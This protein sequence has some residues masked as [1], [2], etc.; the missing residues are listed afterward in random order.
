MDEPK[1]AIYLIAVTQQKPTV[2]ICMRNRTLKSISNNT[3][4]NVLQTK[5]IIFKK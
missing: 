4:F 2:R 3:T 1:N 5:I